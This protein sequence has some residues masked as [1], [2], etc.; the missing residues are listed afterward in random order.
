MLLDADS[1]FDWSGRKKYLGQVCRERLMLFD[2]KTVPPRVVNAVIKT[3]IKRCPIDMVRTGSPP[4]AA[5]CEWIHGQV[6]LYQQLIVENP[7][8]YG[9]SS[10][11][12]PTSP[13]AKGGGAGQASGGGAT[14]D[15]LRPVLLPGPG[16][17]GS[18]YTTLLAR[19]AGQ[20]RHVLAQPGTPVVVFGLTARPDLNGHGGV[21]QGPGTK[22]GRLVVLLDGNTKPMSIREANLRKPAVFDSCSR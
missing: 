6:E 1:H 9:C 13:N 11:S 18:L 3:Y 14:S 21:V 12:A 22:P 5:L 16:D 17:P 7:Q 19:R 15:L 4:A 2:V 10:D 20:G 8:L